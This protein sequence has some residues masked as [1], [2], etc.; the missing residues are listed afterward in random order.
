MVL[1]G[2]THYSTTCC[3]FSCGRCRCQ[4]YFRIDKGENRVRETEQQTGMKK[5]SFFKFLASSQVDHEVMSIKKG[6]T[7]DCNSESV[8]AERAQ[9]QCR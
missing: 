5:Q 1:S 8:M 6:R 2:E 3:S 7:T 4:L 9:Q